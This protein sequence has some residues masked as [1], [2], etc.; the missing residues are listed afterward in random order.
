VADA[1]HIR[2]DQMG[3]G[4][5]LLRHLVR[6][7]EGA[8]LTVLESGVAGNTVMEVDLAPGATL[9]HVRLQDAPDRPSATH[10]FARIADEATFKS[11]TLTAEGSLTRNE[12]VIELAGEHGSGHIAGAVLGQGESHADNTVFV[13]HTGTHGES[14]Q[15]FKNVLGDSA[16]AIFQ[17]KIFVRPGAQK[18]DGYQISQSVLLDA[19]AEFSAK[20]ELEIYADDVQCSHGSTTGALDR[21]AL[22]Y[23]RSRGVPKEEAEALLVLS[24]IDPAIQEIADERIADAARERVAAWMGAR[25]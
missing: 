11:F 2:Q 10:V 18:T 14:R 6:V 13:T 24:F 22:F 19:G 15:V 7:E 12:M 21:D 9:H 25:R 17:G 16:K 1:V 5:S 8:E 23:M 4:A 3:E 20:P